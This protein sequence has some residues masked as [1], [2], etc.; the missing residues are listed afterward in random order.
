MKICSKPSK[1]ELIIWF[2]S[3]FIIIIS[4]LCADQKEYLTLLASIIGATA[5]IFVAKGEPIGQI[6]TVVFSVFYSV[7]SLKFHYYGEMITYLGMTAPIAFMRD[8]KS[9]V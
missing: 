5:L 6:L 3:V 2:C 7:I 4:F 9:V 8:R 1:T